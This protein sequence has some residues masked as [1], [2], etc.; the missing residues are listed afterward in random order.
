MA[1]CGFWEKEKEPVPGK[2]TKVVL[3][4]RQRELLTEEALPTDF[5]AL[6]DPQQEALVAIEKMLCF[7]EEKYG[8]EFSYCG[9]LAGGVLENEQLIA[10]E[11]GGDRDYDT[12]TVTAAENIPADPAAAPGVSDP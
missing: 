5:E 4:E 7:L 1:G 2:E 11:K 9:Y 10:C 3:N 8:R 12:F 6:P